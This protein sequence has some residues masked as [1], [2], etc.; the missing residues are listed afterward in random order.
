MPW[1][2]KRVLVFSTI[3]VDKFWF[4]VESFGYIEAIIC[5]ILPAED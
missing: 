5:S 3:S 4:T 2:A 1:V